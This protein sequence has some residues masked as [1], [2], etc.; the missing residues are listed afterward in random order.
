MINYIRTSDLRMDV[1][2]SKTRIIR[3]RKTSCSTEREGR[4]IYRY[5]YIIT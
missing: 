5:A 3:E 2:K 1:E 4:N